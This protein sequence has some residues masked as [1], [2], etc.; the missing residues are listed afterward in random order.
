M[1]RPL[2]S[3]VIPVMVPSEG[4]VDTLASLRAHGGVPVEALLQPVGY[5]ALP[6]GVQ[7]AGEGALV[8]RLGA[9]QAETWSALEA[10][11]RAASGEWI[12]FLQPGERLLAGA[13]E[14]AC[15]LAPARTLVSGRSAVLAANGQPGGLELPWPF[16]GHFRQ[17]AFW[18]AGFQALPAPS[19]FWPRELVTRVGGLSPADAAAPFY[20]LMCRYTRAHAVLAI[21][22]FLA[23]TAQLSSFISSPEAFQAHLEVSRRHWGTPLGWRYWRCRLA[24]LR[25]EARL[26]DRA[27]RH[28]ARS[29]NPWLSGSARARSAALALALAPGAGLRALIQEPLAEELRRFFEN[30]PI[31]NGEV[32]ALG[33][34]RPYADGWVGPRLRRIFRRLERGERVIVRGQHR[35][36]HAASVPLQLE[37]RIDGL[38]A[39]RYTVAAPGPFEFAWPV[40][41]KGIAPRCVELLAEPSFVPAEMLGGSDRRELSF[42]LEA[43]T[44]AR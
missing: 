17:L 5:D 30:L 21:D 18:R 25:H 44:L 20:A 37:L 11:L 24:L 16:R 15:A 1:V 34:R 23:E 6:P 8:V 3:F 7:A 41:P 40:P 19:T 22:D 36:P 12:S 29:R 26:S 2:H 43:L 10:G 33:G 31:E 28:L 35:H 32:Q 38:P 42:V 4:L 27:R 14:R 13:L 39:A 9:P